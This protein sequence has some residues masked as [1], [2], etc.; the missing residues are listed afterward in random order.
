MPEI[1]VRGASINYRQ[2]GKGEPLLLIHGWNA[3][4][5]MWMLNLRGLSSERRVIAVDLPGH[6]GSG[7][8]E[9]FVPDLA[10]YAGFIEDLRRALFLPSLDLVGHSMGGSISLLYA[11]DHPDRVSRLVL[12]DT[13]A[14]RKAIHLIA[15][16]TS[17]GPGTW[18]Y[19]HMHGRRFRTYM[20]RRALACPEKLPDEVLEENLRLS[21]G[22]SREVF[23]ATTLAVRR[24]SIDPVAVAAMDLPVL[25]MWG[26]RDK[27]VSLK[28]ARRLKELLPRANV[29][30]VP[31]AA[32][33]PQL[34]NPR[35][36]EKLIL[37]FL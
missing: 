9:D 27:T 31:E 25:L 16:L 30:L 3:S 5:A 19:N 17:P 1:K 20:F 33:S 34:D 11:L 29:V 21:A 32:H 23:K 12:M 24:V 7:L 10:G 35:L 26:D 2:R 14:D 4:S 15:R 6:G 18:L 36:V 8:P 28:E 22:I 37:A 13:P